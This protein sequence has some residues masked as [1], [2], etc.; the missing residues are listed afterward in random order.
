MDPSAGHTSDRINSRITKLLHLN[1]PGLSTRVGHRGVHRGG[2]RYLQRANLF[3]ADNVQDTACT[4]SGARTSGCWATLYV[5]MLTSYPPFQPPPPSFNGGRSGG[6]GCEINTGAPWTRAATDSPPFSPPSS[7]LVARRT[8]R[9]NR[10]KE[11]ER[12][13]ER[14]RGREER[15]RGRWKTKR[16]PRV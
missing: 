16:G 2:H 5:R 3:K 4:A 12:E 7:T 8:R 9:R 15:E 6:V 10:G 11:R 14:G 13:R 1:D